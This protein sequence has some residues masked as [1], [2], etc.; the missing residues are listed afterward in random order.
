M[1]LGKLSFIP[2]IPSQADKEESCQFVTEKKI[3]KIK[4]C[5]VKIM[6]SISLPKIAASS[7]VN[8]IIIDN[9]LESL[10]FVYRTEENDSM[11]M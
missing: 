9:H 5:W 3:Q 4:W 8:D 11:T 7:E 2:F 10:P 6:P 1:V